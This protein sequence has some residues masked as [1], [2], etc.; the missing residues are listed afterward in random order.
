M[1]LDPGVTRWRHDRFALPSSV[2][3]LD[4]ADIYARKRPDRG[5]GGENP[6][7]SISRTAAPL[8]TREERF[9]KEK[10]L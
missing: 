7:I 1:G 10:I 5:Y 4:A 8:F 2:I 3:T 9:A 6:M